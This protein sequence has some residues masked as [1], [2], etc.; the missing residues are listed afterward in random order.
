MSVVLI[1][2]VLFRATSFENAVAVFRGMIGSPISVPMFGS[3]TETWD[4]AGSILWLPPLPLIAL[5]CMVAEHVVWRTRG[6]RWM[7]LPANLWFTPV[8]TAMMIWALVLYA[9][10]GFHPFVYFQF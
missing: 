7:R 4:A 2:W 3:E 8:A 10:R 6:R 5:A 9:P 1:G